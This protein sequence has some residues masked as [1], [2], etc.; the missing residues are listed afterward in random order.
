MS[1]YHK[2]GNLAPRDIASRAIF[3][4]MKKA[5]SKYVYLDLSK[6]NLNLK[7]RF[8]SIYNYCLQENIDITK[9]YIPISP[10]AHYCMGGVKSDSFGRTNIS[11][12]FA[13][14]EV[15]STG[16]HGANRL[17]SNSLLEGVIFG[18][19]SAQKAGTLPVINSDETQHLLD[20]L[21]K[22]KWQDKP[23]SKDRLQKIKSEIRDLM[24]NNVGIIRLRSDIRKTLKTLLKYRHVVKNKSFDREELELQNIL[25]SSVL[26]SFF[27]YKRKESRG[28]HFLKDFNL[29]NDSLKY[30]VTYGK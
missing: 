24:W 18:S 17:A 20:I 8:P 1:K 7:E 21:N 9:D 22:R 28:S 26:I 5:N 23:L 13:I 3:E 29:P 19:R 15:A 10:A 14:G 27:A 4:E 11:R 16:V 30:P 12:L 6:I 25:Y 2:D